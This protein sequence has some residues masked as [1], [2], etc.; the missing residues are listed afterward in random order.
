MVT[1][2]LTDDKTIIIKIASLSILREDEWGDLECLYNARLAALT[3][4]RLFTDMSW[5]T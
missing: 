5:R 3:D 2:I 1:F 4:G